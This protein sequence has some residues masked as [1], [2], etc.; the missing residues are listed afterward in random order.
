MYSSTLPAK[1]FVTTTNLAREFWKIL[2]QCRQ[3]FKNLCHFLNK[4]R[5][6]ILTHHFVNAQTLEN[7]KCVVVLWIHHQ[8]SQDY[9]VYKFFSRIPKRQ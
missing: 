8:A 9:P 5:L 1:K 7:Q 4:K 3:L 2:E 6:S